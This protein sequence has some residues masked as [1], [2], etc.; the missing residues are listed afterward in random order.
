MMFKTNKWII[1]ILFIGLFLVCTHSAF[2][3][4][5]PSQEEKRIIKAFIES[6]K[7][8]QDAINDCKKEEEEARKAGKNKT[9]K[10]WKD[11]ATLFEGTARNYGNT[12]VQKTDEYYDIQKPAGTTIEYDPNCTVYAKVPYTEDKNNIKVI[13]CPRALSDGPGL[14][15]ST[16][17]HEL[18]H[19]RQIKVGDS[20]KPGYWEN[21]TWW[22]HYAEQLSYDLEEI[23]YDDGIT[24][25]MPASEKTMIIR[26]RAYHSKGMK[27]NPK[28]EIKTGNVKGR[29]GETATVPLTVYNPSDS[30]QT[31]NLTFTNEKGWAT[32]PASVIG[33]IISPEQEEPFNVQVQIPMSAEVGSV[34]AFNVVV[35]TSLTSGTDTVMIYIPPDIKVTPGPEKLGDR[36]EWVEV[37]F[38]VQNEGPLPDICNLEVTNPLGWTTIFTSPTLALEPMQAADVKAQVQVDAG[39]SSRTTNLIFCTAASQIRPEHSSTQWVPITVKDRDIACLAVESP[40][41]KYESGEMFIPIVAVRNMGYVDSFFDVFL[42]TEPFGGGIP[43]SSE[44]ITVPSLQP[45][46]MKSVAFPPRS[47]AT[48]GVYTAKARVALDGDVETWNDTTSGSFEIQPHSGVSLWKQY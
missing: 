1:G 2:C 27:D 29:A 28:P 16:K 33:L 39:A 3:V 12:A 19:A 20:S 4:K 30:P 48:P 42:D 25:D 15:A 32:I 10:I 35:E 38:T 26:S 37:N 5:K 45:G 17:I 43:I 22:G 13:I 11:A 36:G 18:E 40:I 47:I 44:K 8:Y 41:D 24:N 34:S 14:L 9:A 31:V 46:Q 23:Y 7:I 6:T 21:C